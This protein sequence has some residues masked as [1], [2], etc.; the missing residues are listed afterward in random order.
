[1]VDSFTFTDFINNIKATY[2]T[3]FELELLGVLK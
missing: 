3:L 2:L 1:M